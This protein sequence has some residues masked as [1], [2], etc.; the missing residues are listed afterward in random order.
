[1]KGQIP[2]DVLSENRMPDNWFTDEITP[3]DKLLIE[4][5]AYLQRIEFIETKNFD[6]KL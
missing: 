2:S 6:D 4:L 5:A 1:L 3:K